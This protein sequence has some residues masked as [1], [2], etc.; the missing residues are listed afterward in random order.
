MIGDRLVT[1]RRGRLSWRGLSAAVAVLVVWAAVA[2]FGGAS[3]HHAD[4]A[5][6]AAAAPGTASGAGDADASGHADAPD[7]GHGAGDAHTDPVAAEHG[8]AGHGEAHDGGHGGGGHADPVAPIL[9]ALTLVLVGAKVGGDVFERMGQPS[10][11]GELIVGVIMG[12]VGYLVGMELFVALREGPIL[13]EIAN[14]VMGGATWADAARQV[15]PAAM[16]ETAG[17]AGDRLVA[18]LQHNPHVVDTVKVVDIFSRIGVILLLFL[19]GLESSLQE[20]AKVGASALVVAVIGVI[21]PFFL[22]YF[23]STW[24]LPELSN[25]VHIFIGATL[26]A[27]SV[28]ITARVFKDLGKLHT[29][30]A[31]IILGAAVIDDVLGLIILAVVSGVIQSGKLEMGSVAII[32]GKAIGFLVGAILVGVFVIPQITKAVAL[33]RVEGTKLVYVLSLCFVMSWA[34]NE[35][36]LA[37]IVGAF[38]AGLVLTETQFGAFKGEKRHMEE[39]LEP[40]AGFLVP[41]FFVLMGIQVKL[42]TFADTSVLGVA[43]ALTVAAFIG[44]QVCGFGVGKGIDR[45]SVGVGM[46]PRG[47]VGLIFAS[48]GRGLGVVNDAVFSAVVIMVIVTTLVTPVLLKIT[49]NR[50]GANRG[51]GETLGAA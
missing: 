4:V 20:M 2:S 45:L 47:E 24:L 1:R 26:C 51:S 15:L 33:M 36:G 29:I 5:A 19:V 31:K 39:L 17:G 27:T 48:I 42:E 22:G 35:I 49:L 14:A 41:V 16:F 32:S 40:I 11:L 13:N 37:T 3:A 6:P 10:V 8:A 28:G 23:S 9:I 18:I 21:A 12:N 38:A 25:N 50:G 43:A 7:D 46:V 30:E 34:A 44:K